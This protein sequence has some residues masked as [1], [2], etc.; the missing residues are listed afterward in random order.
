MKIRE[1]VKRQQFHTTYGTKHTSVYITRKLRS[2]IR[3]MY[4]K[5]LFRMMTLIKYFK[6]FEIDERQLFGRSSFRFKYAKR[7]V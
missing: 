5:K 1:G 4:R 6:S 3:H 2:N 7:V